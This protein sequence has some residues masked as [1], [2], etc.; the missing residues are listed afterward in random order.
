MMK[1]LF[2]EDT[3]ALMRHVEGADEIGR[4]TLQTPKGELSW[5]Y[6]AAGD[7]KGWRLLL[8]LASDA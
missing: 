4:V 2:L 3:I 7:F 8:G 1:E 6:G 5:D